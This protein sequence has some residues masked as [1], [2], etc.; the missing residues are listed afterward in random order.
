MRI[1]GLSLQH[2]LAAMVVHACLPAVAAEP[3]PADPIPRTVAVPVRDQRFDIL[4]IAVDGNTRLNDVDIQLALEPFVGEGRKASDVD[5]ARSALEQLYKQRGYKS[6]AVTIPKQTIKDGLVL[7]EVVEGKVGSLEV[8][9]S[10][11]SSIDQI[12]LEVPSLAEGQVPDFAKVEQELNYVNRLGYRRVTPVLALAAT[13][14]VI[15]V[16]LNVD[17]QLP[18]RLSAEVNNRHGRDTS[19]MRTV[20][21]AGYDNLFQLGHSVT[22]SV[23]LAPRRIDDGRVY[24]GSYRIPLGDGSWNLSATALR[25][26]SN[27]TALSG[28]DVNGSGRSFG[29]SLGKQWPALGGVY[30]PGI[31]V[32]IDYKNFNTLASVGPGA[33]IRTPVEYLPV[34]LSLTQ[35]LRLEQQ[36]LQNDFR[37]S[38]ASP[39]LGS[40]AD[41][42]DL[43][44]FKARGQMLQLRN[45]ISYERRLPGAFGLGLRFSTQITD[46]PL[47]SSE[48]FAGGGMDNVRGYL[49]AEVLGDYGYFA[50]A[51]LRAP[52]LSDYVPSSLLRRAVSEFQPY[53]YFDSADLK[54]RG[55]FL[56]NS[57]PRAKYLSSFGFGLSFKLID[58]LSGTL[59]WAMPLHRGAVTGDGD[60]R[61]LFRISASL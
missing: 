16:D 48:Q 46:Q 14:G 3:A 59:D 29:L 27:V 30:Y 57:S 61:L 8:I 32:G 7:L 9:G 60:S 49:E 54:L 44:R 42:I 23:Q 21:T 18:L 19:F 25:T 28:V 20:L 51:E 2:A 53:A 13:P 24:Y 43:N 35:L 58:H 1:A 4:E 26:G 45:S 39:K 34:T 5:A 33:E 15:D 6:V 47:I 12:K 31:S 22:L 40:D 41:T 36:S 17:D 55:P 37:L 38:V 10:R 50:S 11:Y 52:S 56:D